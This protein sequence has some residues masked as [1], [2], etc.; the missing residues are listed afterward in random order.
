MLNKTLAKSLNEQVKWELYSSYLYLSMSA[1][2]QDAG[3]PGF[4]HWMRL[5]AQ[6]ELQHALKFYDYILEHG[7][8]AVLETIDAPPASWKNA[9]DVF[10]KTLEHE[11]SVTAR[12]NKLAALARKEEDFASE[13]FLHWF[14]TEQIEEEANVSAVLSQ[15]KL[16]K[17]EGQGLLLLDRELGAR[18]LTPAAPAAE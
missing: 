13:I 5:Q 11:R 6:E 2:F 7:N 15:L 17:G 3:L 8:K 18:T 12:I 16:I 4:A 9:V 1:Y 14:V 10:D